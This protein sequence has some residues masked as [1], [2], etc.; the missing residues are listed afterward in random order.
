MPESPFG[1]T[2]SAPGPHQ[3]AQFAQA[4]GVYCNYCG[5]TPA[6]DLDFRAHRGLIFMMQFRKYPGPF[7]RECGL[8]TFREMTGDSL[9]QGWWGPISAIIANP[10]T[11]LINTIN[12]A[13]LQQLPPP[14]PGAPSL[15]MDPGRPL[16]QRPTIIGLF[17]P[18]L[19]IAFIAFGSSNSSGTSANHSNY[20]YN[21][22]PTTSYAMPYVP[23]VPS[24]VAPTTQPAHDAKS[25]K[26]GDCVYDSNGDIAK[27]DRPK[28]EVVSCSDPRARATVLGKPTGPTA[29]T[30]CDSKYPDTDVII[31]HSTSF[32]GGPEIKDFAL[33]LQLK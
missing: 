4:N 14:I 11:L 7:C 25:A 15:P 22:S 20:N 18:I 23:V 5:A 13:R 1:A 16:W 19:A 33:C 26:V 28:V 12:R 10:V 27:D 31:T 24:I 29:D 3:A 21:Y 8:A 6:I 32:N 2:Q 9:V 30:E 17:V